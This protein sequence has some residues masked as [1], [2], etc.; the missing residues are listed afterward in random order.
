MKK[1]IKIIALILT[2]IL[3]QGTFII[4][5]AEAGDW[6]EPIVV[7]GDFTANIVDG[8]S[9]WYKFVPEKTGVYSIYSEG[10]C[11]TAIGL[12]TALYQNEGDAS[13]RAGLKVSYNDGEGHNFNVTYT[14]SAGRLYYLDVGT[15][16][17]QEAEFDVKI[18]FLGEITEV[19]VISYPARDTYDIGD[20]VFLYG[21]EDRYVHYLWMDDFE[22]ELV[23]QDGTTR[24]INGYEGYYA[25]NI[26]YG[27]PVIGTNE[28]VFK[29]GD[30]VFFTWEI[31]ITGRLTETISKGKYIPGTTREPTFLNWFLYI[32][33]FGWIWMCYD[34]R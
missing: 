25:F 15:E 19:N 2:A 7:T 5:G 16:R 24:I 18:D 27:K 20:E 23:L 12:C 1:Y 13:Y 21:G 33:C 34:F 17:N 29:I 31:T 4:A 3:V 9:L 10:D 32:V 11:D 22:I 14:L 28:I 6:E 8:K 30:T 26:E